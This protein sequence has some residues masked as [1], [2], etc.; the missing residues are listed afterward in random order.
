MN[1]RKGKNAFPAV[2]LRFFIF[3]EKVMPS[4]PIIGAAV[5]RAKGAK[6][7]PPVRGSLKRFSLCFYSSV[8]PASSNTRCVSA[9]QM[10][11][12]TSPMCAL[13]SSSMHMRLWPT[14]PPMV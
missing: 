14:P 10:E 3:F 5:L 7:L 6:K 1:A 8:M 9:S 2:H 4:T 13:P 11:D 12:C